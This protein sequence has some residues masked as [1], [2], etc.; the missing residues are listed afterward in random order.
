A[1]NVLLWA[2]TPASSR[3]ELFAGDAGSGRVQLLAQVNAEPELR[4]P[5]LVIADLLVRP[6]AADLLRVVNACRR[7]ALWAE[8]RGALATALEFMQAGALSSPDSASLAF[9]VG[10]LA[11]RLA[12]YDRAESWYTRAAVQARE[13]QDWRSYAS[14]LAG[15]GNLHF[16]RGNIPAAKRLHLRCLHTATRHQLTEMVAAAYHNLF[17]AEVEMQAGLE[18]DVLAARALAAYGTNMM[19][20]HRLAYD[21]AYH[22]AVRGYFN[23]SLRVASALA[24]VIEEPVMKPLVHGLI[25]RAAGGVGN[26]ALFEVATEQVDELLSDPAIPEEMTA[27]T[28]LGVAHGALSLGELRSAKGVAEEAISIAR[29]RSEGRVM[30]E[31]EAVLQAASQDR[32]RATQVSDA[33]QVPELAD[34]FVQLLC[35]RPSVQLASV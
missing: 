31:A 29:K 16:Q 8:Q 18:V 22:W 27:R 12:D 32:R 17:D 6:G 25:A 2:E 21:V 10:R 20:V 7:I 30:L 34:Q 35:D 26:R 3:G 9:G 23:G 19:G 15:I 24:T 4:A 28:L 11:R 14:A 13:S 1:R 5:L 33:T